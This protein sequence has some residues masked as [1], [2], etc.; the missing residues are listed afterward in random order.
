VFATADDTDVSIKVSTTLS[1]RLDEHGAYEWRYLDETEVIEYDAQFILKRTFQIA[2][3]ATE[4]PFHTLANGT[5]FIRAAETPVLL[6]KINTD[7]VVRLTPTIATNLWLSPDIR[8]I[9]YE[10][11]LIVRRK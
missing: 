5:I 3:R 2:Q 10:V 1:I 9:E 11:E 8:C 4:V 6:L 7:S